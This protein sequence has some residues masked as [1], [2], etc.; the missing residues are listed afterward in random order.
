MAFKIIYQSYRL[1]NN[2]KLIVLHASMCFICS[3]IRRLCVR[4]KNR[5]A[6]RIVKKTPVSSRRGFELKNKFIQQIQ[7]QEIYTCSKKTTV[8]TVKKTIIVHNNITLPKTFYF[9]CA[10]KS[11]KKTGSL[12]AYTCSRNKS[13]TS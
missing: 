8:Y 11:F 2:F 3:E 10:L 13:S 5:Q 4:G 1:P 7:K 9:L 6:V 12:Y